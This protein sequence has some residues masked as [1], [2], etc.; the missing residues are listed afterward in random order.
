MDIR[1]RFSKLDM[2]AK[3]PLESEEAIRDWATKVS[4]LLEF[5]IHLKVGFE[6]ARQNYLS[7]IFLDGQ[8]NSVK[9]THLK[10]MQDYLKSAIEEINL[11]IEEDQN[12]DEEYYFNQN[13]QLSTQKTL[14]SI[15]SQAK[16][17]LYV[18]DP[19]MGKIII[20]ELATNL[21]EVKFLTKEPNSLFE[22]RLK[23]A[24]KELSSTKIEVRYSGRIHDRYLIL[25][26]KNIWVVG[27]SYGKNL[28]NKSIYILKIDAKEIIQSFIVDFEEIW[29]TSSLEKI[30]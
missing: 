16:D 3:T 14:S 30:K 20:E 5:N 4:P 13:S 23:A 7:P 22:E 15:I 6:C 8:E 25:D 21:K 18:C 17:T 27:N 24:K 28:G 1:T 2:L 9:A 26:K 12:D 11:K 29:S 19:Y 10:G